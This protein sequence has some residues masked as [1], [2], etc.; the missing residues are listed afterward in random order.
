MD[1]QIIR[2]KLAPARDVAV[3]GGAGRGWG[4]ALARAA[5]DSLGLRLDCAPVRVGSGSLA[6]L[7]ER[8]PERALILLLEGPGGGGGVLMLCPET[9]AALI[10]VQTLGKVTALP[11]PPRKPTRTDAA[12]VA[13]WADRALAGLEEALLADDDLVW[14]DGFRQAGFL[15]EP[16]P[17][18][19]VLE[20]VPW[21]I[22]QADCDLGGLRRGQILLALPTEGRGR[23]PQ[24]PL[25]AARP[26][27]DESADFAVALEEQVMAAEAQVQAELLRLTMPLGE[28]MSLK[29]GQVL[30]LPDAALDRIDLCGVDGRLCA[31]GRLGQQRGMRAVRIAQCGE[32][33]PGVAEASG[34]PVPLARA[35]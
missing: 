32:V 21:Q 19:L 35:G 6:E 10:E 23:Q 17:L 16:R 7:L 27:Q 31:Q 13:E 3:P 1:Q 9:L 34:A 14:T 2:R 30:P 26:E 25:P 5:R 4:L 33:R 28:L 15:D 12:M 20:D 8:A 24:R 22:M 11:V 29:P 18:A